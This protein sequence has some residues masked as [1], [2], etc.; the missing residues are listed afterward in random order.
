MKHGLKHGDGSRV[1]LCYNASISLEECG[2]LMDTTPLYMIH[3]LNRIS[4]YRLPSGYHFRMF[5]Y[6]SDREHWANIVTD[7]GEF[8]SETQALQRFDREFK[9]YLNQVKK[10]IIFIET[11]DKQV[12]GTAAAWFGEWN[13]TIIGRLHW[14]EIKP[15]HQGQKLGKPLVANAL[16]LLQRYHKSAFVKTQ[17]TSLTAIY[18]YQQFG[19]KTVIRT[20]Q[21]QHV[22]DDVLRQLNQ[23]N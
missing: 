13:N 17:A 7:T 5:T 3:D 16:Q 10:R 8:T 15:A 4:D 2:D 14:I 22:W 20:Q 1:S 6:N 21:E 18:I 11:D 9:P 19:F 12:V 23:S